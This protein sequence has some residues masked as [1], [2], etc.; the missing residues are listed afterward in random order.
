MGGGCGNWGDSDECADENAGP[1]G[2]IKP[3][4][5]NSESTLQYSMFMAMRYYGLPEPLSSYH[6]IAS[7]AKRLAPAPFYISVC[8]DLADGGW[9]VPICR[10]NDTEGA[11][12]RAGIAVLREAGVHVLHYTHTRLAYWPNGSEYKCCACCERQSYVERRVA[13][14]TTA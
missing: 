2:I 10:R 11:A 12:V 3:H 14:E 7:A 9:I 4:P 6:A 13:E 5:I 1:G 8:C